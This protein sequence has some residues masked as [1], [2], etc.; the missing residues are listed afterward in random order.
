MNPPRRRQRFLMELVRL[1]E[2]K[3]LSTVE[4][5]VKVLEGEIDYPNLEKHLKKELDAL[6][7]DLLKEIFEALEQKVYHSKDRKRRWKVVRRNDEKVILTPFGQ[8][9]YK[10]TYYRHK[11]TKEYAYL[12]DER[13]GITPH[14]RVSTTVK[15]EVVE[16]AAQASYETATKQVSRYNP[17]LKVS[18]QTAATCVKE[19][20]AKELQPPQ[21]KRKVEALYIEADEDHLT[22]RGKKGAQARL[23]YIHEGVKEED[24]HRRSLKRVKH[25]TTVTKDTAEFWLEVCD[26]IDAYYEFESIKEIYLS[27]DGGKWIRAGQEYIPKVTFILDKFH[28]SKAIL[29][30]TAHVPELKIQI[31]RDIRTLKKQNVVE[32][33]EKALTL[34][35]EQ[36]RQKRINDTISYIKNN[37]DGIEAAVKHPHVGC[38]AEGHIS[39]ILAARMSS[40]PM[41]WSIQGA[42]KMASM[43]AVKANGESVSEHYIASRGEKP[44]LIIELKEEVKNELKRL[45]QKRSFGKENISNVP[46]FQ[47]VSNCTRVALRGLNGR[48][49]V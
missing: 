2:Q 38:S 40:R 26:Y 24:N 16:G 41:A 6:G 23:I 15:S 37:W 18:K 8:L 43:R 28:L 25:F 1:V 48:T 4:V 14:M 9:K 47:G 17:E 30:A 29:R 7:C 19:F 27:G 12:V 5:I 44:P 36:A 34:A 31:Y 42:E 21:Q 46:V 32:H 39:H 49:V 22:V 3:V 45:K 13:A 33:L 35:E 20:K 11:Q 10:R